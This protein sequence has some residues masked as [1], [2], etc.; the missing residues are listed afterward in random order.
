MFVMAFR[1]E[2]TRHEIAGENA[3]LGYEQELR[4]W[5]ETNPKP[6]FKDWLIHTKR[7]VPPMPSGELQFGRPAQSERQVLDPRPML[8]KETYEAEMH[9][10]NELR[11]RDLAK[12]KM[13]DEP[14]QA[15]QAEYAVWSGQS[16]DLLRTGASFLKFDSNRKA[17]EAF[18]LGS[19]LYSDAGVKAL[20]VIHPD[21]FSVAFHRDVA[22]AIVYQSR[23]GE[24]HDAAAISD[25]LREAG[26]LPA[27][28]DPLACMVKVDP[29]EYGLG[30]W[31]TYAPMPQQAPGFAQA[32]R[33]EYRARYLEEACVQTAAQARGAIEYGPA[34]LPDNDLTGK[35][36]MD[37]AHKL[38]DM[39]K[40]LDPDLKE[41]ASTG[42][43]ESVDTRE[44]VP[45]TAQAWKVPPDLH[46][47]PPPVLSG[48]GRAV[49]SR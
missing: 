39:P 47:P 15:R 42:S 26:R 19:A 38:M 37:L 13:F 14:R 49:S 20:Q 28:M 30:A 35:A 18:L 22:R 5:L 29:R 6:L 33:A 34:G 45:A 23:R 17:N 3:S 12:E 24:P 41:R 40:E 46:L 44:M 10:V 43:S 27:S 2:S 32:V 11:Q 1:E 36:R 21:E 8:P 4:D 48:A 31:E 9:R 7:E 16:D 25:M